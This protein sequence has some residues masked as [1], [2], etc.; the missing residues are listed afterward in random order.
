MLLLWLN[1]AN[2][3]VGLKCIARSDRNLETVG[4]S[5]YHYTD[6]F[7][8]LELLA[9]IVN[10]LLRQDGSNLERY[11]SWLDM[12]CLNTSS[13]LAVALQCS[14]WPNSSCS[15]LLSS[16]PSSSLFC[17]NPDFVLMFLLVIIIH[18]MIYTNKFQLLDSFFH[19]L[20]IWYHSL[21]HIIVF[22]LWVDT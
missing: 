18:Q 15:W 14:A 8:D 22:V 21:S 2:S 10:G 5:I 11:P 13:S 17:N 6:V 9:A 12:R 4:V 16:L 3:K 19:L 1:C 20:E 7:W